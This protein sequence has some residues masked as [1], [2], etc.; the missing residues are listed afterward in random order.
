LLLDLALGW[1]IGRDE[2]F[3]RDQ[4]TAH[5]LEVTRVGLELTRWVLWGRANLISCERVEQVI[6]PIL[7]AHVRA[8]EFV[9]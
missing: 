2:A 9:L 7:H 8:E 5:A 1:I 6:L 3:L 4:H